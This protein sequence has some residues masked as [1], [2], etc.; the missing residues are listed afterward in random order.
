MRE[1]W[2]TFSVRDHLSDAPFV[3]EVLLYDRLII[4][5]PDASDIGAEAFWADEGWKP[6]VLQNCLDILKVKTDNSDGL[7]LTIA[8]DKSKR[9]RFESKMSTAAALA[10]QQ[11]DPDRNYYID[12]FAMTRELLKDDFRPALPPGVAKAWTVAAYPSTDAFERDLAVSDA[13]RRTKLA[14]V[15]RHRFLTPAQSDPKHEMLKR[16]VDLSSSS[17]FRKKRARFYAWQEQIIAEDISN[18]KA[19]EELDQLLND[20]NQAT[21]AA[22]G[23]VVGRYV[24]TVI[25]I[26]LTMAGAMLAGPGAGLVIAAASGLIELARFWKFDRNPVIENGDLDAAAM[27]HDARKG[28]P[29]I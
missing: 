5:V 1:R 24:F 28:L 20:Y 10:M 7:A 22:L 23:A 26:G 16:A 8:W 2:G 27:M 6:D 29:L 12:P 19:I 13:D 17:D 25:P 14:G 3:S 11:R 4:P 9:E 18:E 15:M 21:R